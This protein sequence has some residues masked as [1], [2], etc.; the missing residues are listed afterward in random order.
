[1]VYIQQ[2]LEGCEHSYTLKG[3]GTYSNTFF[4]T[5]L[6]KVILN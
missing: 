3:Q 5:T 2:D 6:T 1:M 4:S